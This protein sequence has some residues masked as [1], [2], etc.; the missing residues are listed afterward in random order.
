[1]AASQY[2]AHNLQDVGGL[3][4]EQII[5]ATTDAVDTPL[6]AMIEKSAK[7]FQHWE[8]ECHAFYTL[9]LDRGL[10]SAAAV[11][12][13]IEALPPKSFESKTYY[14]KWAAALATVSLGR[15][16]IT[17]AELD[18]ALGQPSSAPPIE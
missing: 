1:M 13:C 18:A 3:E 11:R 5:N 16:I 7:G 12:R 17:E 4:T 6:Q 15:G 14:E 10:A 8:V 9:L 2:Y